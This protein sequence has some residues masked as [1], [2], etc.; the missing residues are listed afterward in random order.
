[1]NYTFMKNNGSCVFD[2]P[3]VRSFVRTLKTLCL[4]IGLTL[5]LFPGSALVR[6][7]E[8]PAVQIMDIGEVSPGMRGYGLTVFQGTRIDTFYVEILGVMK[9]VYYAKHDLIMARISGPY[10]DRAGVI[11]GMSGSPVYIEGRLVGA[12]AYSFGQLPK[13]PIGAI[14]PIGQMLAIQNAVVND[15]Q[16]QQTSPEDPDKSP[17]RSN[18]RDIRSSSGMEGRFSADSYLRPISV[19]LIFSGFDPMTLS[20]FEDRLRQKGLIPT[21]GGGG[22]LSGAATGTGASSGSSGAPSLEPGSA[23]GVQLIRG[24]FSLSATGTVT[25]RNGDTILAFGHPFLWS[26][27][28][29]V[30]MTKADII[31]VIP[32]QASSTKLGNVTEPVGS[33]LWDHTNGLY[34]KLG[35]A[36]PMIPVSIAF[37][38]GE[39]LTDT[40]SFEVMMATEWT[41]ILVNMAVANTILG[42]GRL[43]GERTIELGGRVKMRGYPDILLKDLF[44]GQLTLPEMTTDVTSMLNAVLDNPF[45][46]PHI[47]SM[48]LTIRSTND[49]RTAQI[50]GVWFSAEEIAAGDT[51]GV[52]VFLRPY[53]GGR[54]TKRVNIPLPKHLAPGSLQVIVSASQGLIQYDLRSTPQRY[55]PEEARQLIDLLNRRRTNNRIYIRLSQVNAGGFVKGTE[56][57][58]LPPSILSIMNSDRTNGSFT[59]T[60]ELVLIEQA[61]DTDYVVAGQSAGRLTVKR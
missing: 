16:T 13:E 37:Y 26:G 56:M 29:N 50:E 9:N 43:G 36:T 58:A 3:G 22:A 2:K 57:P 15:S 8:P 10:V 54:E 44:S 55:R 18:L 12:L 25:Y 1:M 59:P 5:L 28:L 38:S 42:N 6:A 21:L 23:V 46:T 30:P 45:V 33:V 47:E 61:I 20:M 32:D 17:A 53:R 60:R 52:T 19:P 24:D 48:D 7:Q 34:G 49:R 31:A 51:L 39:R 14:T 41:P 4:S 40:Y 35:S 11:A 27:A